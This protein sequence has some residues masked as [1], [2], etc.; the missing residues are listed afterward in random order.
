MIILTNCSGFFSNFFKV[1]N[2][3]LINHGN[4]IIVPYFITRSVKEL[5]CTYS[6]I[7]RHI[8]PEREN[9]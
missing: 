4:T 6:N 2:W 3:E 5:T 8:Y 9:I 7:D 1:L